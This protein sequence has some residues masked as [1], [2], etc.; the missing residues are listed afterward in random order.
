MTSVSARA[1]S[2]GEILRYEDYLNGAI[3]RIHPLPPVWLPAREATGRVTAEPVITRLPAP[4]F[5]NSAMDGFAVNTADL[6][7]ADPTD[8]ELAGAGRATLDAAGAGNVTL[9]VSADIAAG[10]HGM[11]TPGAA[12]RIM[13]GAPLPEGANTV[14]PVEFTD[15]PST[16]APLPPTVKL[17]GDW[18][19]GRNI[20]REGSDVGAGEEIL[21]AG[22]VLNGAALAALAGVGVSQV[23]AHPQV[24]VGVIVTGDE[25]VA[26]APG[27]GQVLDS[28]SILIAAAITEF[29]GLLIHA[30]TSSDD[31]ALFN[32]AVSEVLP[33][34]DLLLT[35]GGA[36]VG[37]HDVARHVLSERGVEFASVGI[38]PA[39]P[40]GFGM[41]DGVPVCALPG[42]PGAV[43][44]SLHAIVRPLLAHLGSTTVPAPA[45]MVVAQGWDARPGMRQFVPV[46][47]EGGSVSPVIEGGVAAHRV[48]SLALAEGLAS[49]APE[50]TEVRPGDVLP[51]L[52]TRTPR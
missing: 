44:V 32:Q 22:T 31:P 4:A 24:R 48:R 46:K 14:I 6:G 26:A 25:V 49:V 17:P 35:T 19:P 11:W 2:R 5:T 36:S 21:P 15:H 8:A 37:A 30:R 34:V 10:T 38:Q 23:R 50:I 40:Q 52:M 42:N 29:G 7:G 43:H 41:I 16:R 20:R 1:T 27:P 13:T 47:V 45:R 12:V 39:K 3:A 18:P 33:G 51:V 9:P 28:N